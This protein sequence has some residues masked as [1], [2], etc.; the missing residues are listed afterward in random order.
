MGFASIGR[1]LR[2]EEADAR[3][4]RLCQMSIKAQC[5][6]PMLHERRRKRS[7]EALPP[8]GPDLLDADVEVLADH[9]TRFSLAGIAEVRRGNA[10]DEHP[11]GVR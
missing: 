11:G 4:V 7:P 5:F 2:G 1:E 6:G 3:Q 9:V 8:A 10:R